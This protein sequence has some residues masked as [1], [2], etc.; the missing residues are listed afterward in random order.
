MGPCVYDLVSLTQDARIDVDEKLEKKI[1]DYYIKNFS[2]IN[3]ESFNLCYK[4]I[5]IQRHLKVLG[6]FRRLALRDAKK[7]Y[8]IHIPRVKNLLKK[9]LRNKEFSKIS[10]IIE[11]LLNVND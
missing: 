4:V 10:K 6:I 5:A 11:P 2:Q 3:L 8:L 1:K 9:N 7:Q